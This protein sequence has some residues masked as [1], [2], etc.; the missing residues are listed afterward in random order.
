MT[1]LP[2]AYR[3]AR[4]AAV[5]SMAV[6]AVLCAGKVTAG[7]AGGSTAVVADG[8]ESGAD[9]L[10]SAAVFMGLLLAARPADWDHPYG[11]GRLESA[12]GL[13]VGVVL[14]FTGLLIVY[15]SL[16]DLSEARPVPAAFTIWAP[17]I[18]GAVKA[19]LATYK[20]RIGRRLRSSSLIADAWNDSV[21]I[22]SAIS[23]AVA[24]GLSQLQ[25]DFFARSDSWGGALVGVI[26]AATGLRVVRD[27]VLD[28][29]DTRPDE[30]LM[31]KVRAAAAGVPGVLDIETQRGRKSGLKYYFDLHIE[32]DPE[33]T[34]RE[35]HAISHR[36]KDAVLAGVP[37][38]ADVLIH[39]EPAGGPFAG[40]ER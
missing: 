29:M 2:E 18:S 17:L 30:E 38:V 15:H 19:A 8:V 10:A 31:E 3:Q 22:L 28:L 39:I 35:S 25:T 24:V 26:V 6:G 12:A 13:T 37:E 11:H 36:V 27:A 7:W 9:V 23:A 21:D 33:L 4:R 16:A 34:V 20:F 14:C 40:A 32:V 1:D 5:L